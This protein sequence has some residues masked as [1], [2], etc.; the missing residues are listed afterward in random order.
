MANAS[1]EFSSFSRRHMNDTA[2]DLPANRPT[3]FRSAYQ[4]N[5]KT[6]AGEKK[7]QSIF[8]SA[9]HTQQ[10]IGYVKRH[11]TVRYG[12]LRLEC[13][14]EGICVRWAHLIVHDGRWSVYDHDIAEIKSDRHHNAQET[15][16]D[17]KFIVCSN[18]DGRKLCMLKRA[19]FVGFRAECRRL[20]L[21]FL[22][23]INGFVLVW[24]LYIRIWIWFHPIFC[25]I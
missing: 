9:W 19:R 6:T 15:N 14:W 7:I 13:Y 22:Q 8:H 11:A 17:L 16:I 2:N 20:T 12:S 24:T 18:W 4:Q 3:S 21:S 10:V 25:S 5:H 23:P 1:T